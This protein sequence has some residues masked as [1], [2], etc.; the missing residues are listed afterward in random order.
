MR[1]AELLRL[2]AIGIAIMC[3]LDPPVV[4]AP[5]PPLPLGIAVVRSSM[6]ERP[7]SNTGADT[8]GSRTSAAAQRLVQLLGDDADARVHEMA[9]PLRLPCD[10]QQPCV[11]VT[12][13][14]P[15]RVPADRRGHT[16]VVRVGEAL[17]PNVAVTA[18]DVLA[19][20]SEAAGVARVLVSGS[21]MAGGR[22]RVRLTDGSAVIGEADHP[23]NGDGETTVSV[24]WWPIASGTRELAV[25]AVTEGVEERTLLDNDGRAFVDVADARWPVIIH[26]RRPAWATTFVRRALEGDP[27]FSID[28]RT[29]VAPSVVASTS[30]S[31][32]GLSD[33][34][35]DPAR[36]VIVGAPEA[37]T[38]DDVARLDRFVRHRGGAIV[39]VP[40][41]PFAGP[42]GRLLAHGWRER[43]DD[44]ASE[45]GGLRASEWLVADGASSFDEPV[46]QS[47]AG[48]TVV[49]TPAGAGRVVV[50]GAMDAWRHRGA[51][52]GFERF[53]RTTVAGLARGAGANVA[54]D[55]EPRWSL[56]GEEVT[57]RVSGRTVR[58]WTERIAT[59]T[60]AC[61]AVA[62]MPIRLWPS[63]GQASFVG[64]VRPP[65]SGA[66]CTVSARLAGLGE[67]RVVVQVTPGGRTSGPAVDANLDAVA[68]R[69]GGLVVSE[70]GLD[71]LAEALRALRSDA[72]TPEAR[73][74]M[75]SLW[76]FPLFA[77]CLAGEW[78]LRRRAGLR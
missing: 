76:W 48:P 3:W 20:H 52:A 21:G 78:W 43:L 41:R 32:G 45:S 68:S 62:T 26:E 60:L 42:V 25:E 53:W 70:A 50:V 31:P 75:R 44:T 12:G 35:L 59:A 64:R 13:G 54:V 27:R 56:P 16:S 65:V 66:T 38:A 28:A 30:S 1:L 4:V 18:V 72:R 71:R 5:Q 74:P 40:D 58:A 37:L 15:I 19:T 17:T 6:D 47:H 33:A 77:G 2:T 14:A 36:V 46:A 10:A 22:T 23:W 7:A 29:D 39:L 49:S 51:D 34:R 63:N 73:H 57:V 69:T 9:D 61:G 55:A 11:V 67:G 8:I 24:P